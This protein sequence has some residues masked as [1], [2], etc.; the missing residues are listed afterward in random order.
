M[1]QNIFDAINPDLVGGTELADILNDFKDALM[2]GLSGPSRPAEIEVG[3]MWVDTTDIASNILRLKLFMGAQ[4]VVL[5]TINTSVGSTSIQGS[6]DF[7]EITRIS[8]DNTGP[9]LSLFKGRDGSPVLAGDTLGSILFQGRD[10]TNVK[11]LIGRI[12]YVTNVNVTGATTGGGYLVIEGTRAGANAVSEFARFINGRLGIGVTAPVHPLHVRGTGTKFDRVADDAV[13]VKTAI[14]KARASNNGQVLA[15]DEIW[16]LD[17]A[18]SDNVGTETI[19]A[20]VVVAATENHTTAAKGTS[21]VMQNTPAGSAAPENRVSFVDKIV[22]VFGRLSIEALERKAQLLPSTAEVL[23]LNATHSFIEVTGTT[24]M[25]L[26]G[27]LATSLSQSFRLYNATT[28]TIVIEHQA[29]D[30]A[31]DN[32]ISINGEASFALQTGKSVEFVRRGTINRWSPLIEGNTGITYNEG[33]ALL[34]KMQV[35]SFEGIT[36]SPQERPAVVGANMVPQVMATP[37]SALVAAGT[38]PNLLIGTVDV[39]GVARPFASFFVE[40]LGYFVTSMRDDAV[41]MTANPFV[42]AAGEIL[43]NGFMAIA[44]T[45]SVRS[46]G[47]PSRAAINNGSAW[48]D[49]CMSF[50]SG[51]NYVA[52]AS[53]G[54][55]RVGRFNFTSGAWTYVTPVTIPT[56]LLSIA[57]GS[58][59]IVAVGGPAS[60]GAKSA[61]VS[62]DDGATWNS[63]DL[64]NQTTYTYTRVRFCNAQFVAVGNDG[65]DSIIVSSPD[66]ETW[67]TR[68]TISGSIL[69]GVAHC[70]G[71]YVAFTDFNTM[72]VQERKIYY[73]TDLAGWALSSRRLLIKNLVGG[74]SHFWGTNFREGFGSDA[75]RFSGIVKSGPINIDN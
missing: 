9:E 14:H 20:K 31:A 15:N 1:S 33:K 47:S 10:D 19:T 40:D 34:A 17:V 27:I 42:A 7:F 16:A 52:V 43:G 69:R 12:R 51:S 4:D 30:A 5:F 67:T 65:V 36:L 25:T 38:V 53:S 28:Q 45:G 68:Y 54:A 74:T 35:E 11:R 32:R 55:Y 6:D 75:T 63:F 2:S 59:R 23:A 41:N 56:P 46:W 66:G 64:P 61:W 58:N 57:E 3:G 44:K 60:G 72:P 24:Q 8:A 22:S 26:K 21:V 49:I 39:S 50:Q 48:E 62:T 73:S 70:N 37:P 18:A 71:L 29:A 13:G